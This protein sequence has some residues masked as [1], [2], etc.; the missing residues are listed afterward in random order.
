MA[1]YCETGSSRIE[2]APAIITMMAMTHAK[3]GRS[4]KNLATEAPGAGALARRLAGVRGGHRVH[5]HARA[6]LLEP[7]DDDL[8]ARLEAG[9]HE[10]GVA[11]GAV[12]DELPALD[13]LLRVHDERGGQPL[14]VAR[15]ALLRH[16]QRLG[17]HAL[18]EPGADEH[19]GQELAA[20][21]RHDGAEADRPGAGI[22]RH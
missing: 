12:G 3:M 13:L 15:D 5:Q 19:A 7:L 18:V 10:P 9:G 16:E 22:D 4:M 17:V 2:I 21:V 20:R 1:G 11:H 6:D 14:L 8:V